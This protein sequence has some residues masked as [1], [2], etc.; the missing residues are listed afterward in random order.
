MKTT[1]I[2]F[3]IFLISIILFVGS[4]TEISAKI[5][6][7]SIDFRLSDP[8]TYCAIEPVN[9]NLTNQKINNVLSRAEEALFEWKYELQRVEP[10]NKLIWE[11]EY[12]QISEENLLLSDCDILMRFIF[13]NEY[14]FL[15]G[16]FLP[17][18]N[19]PEI[20]L[21]IYP[22][23]TFIMHSQ[24]KPNYY[25]I[26]VHEIGHSLSL[27]HYVSSEPH[28]MGSWV[29]ESNSPPS[30]MIPV[31]N[32]N[33]N[34]MRIMN[35][36]VEKTRSIYGGH[37]FYAFS[38]NIPTE[39]LSLPDILPPIELP[40]ADFDWIKV[41][42]DI[43]E[44]KDYGTTHAKISGK[45]FKDRISRGIPVVLIM[46]KPD[47]TTELV[48]FNPTRNGFFEVT[49]IFD[50][51]SPRGTYII[52]SMYKS[53]IQNNMKTLFKV[54]D[55]MEVSVLTSAPE[56]QVTKIS[57]PPWIKSNA[58]W[59]SEGSIR[60]SDFTQ[61]IQYMINNEI[62]KIPNLPEH[63]SEVAESKVPDWIRNNAKW[64]AEGQISDDDFVKGIQYLVGQGIIK[65]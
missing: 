5:F 43:F 54:V 41:S 28:E 13:Q 58:K 17:E 20:N 42:E 36:D 30:I 53:V 33:P 32:V 37:G 34:T 1:G 8:P 64:W 61:G 44:L 60:D 14:S 35:L 50:S 45:L 48:Q 49:L 24:I 63:T 39:I 47:K 18:S 57:L 26:L 25:E 29:F 38:D 55:E 15:L 11:M 7:P 3:S 27:G 23:D 31:Q 2:L 12:K 40:I 21:Y 9:G 19:P 4:S 6:F 16:Q 46:Q 10:E 65:V 52:E 62:I 59:W 56:N 22:D 51:E